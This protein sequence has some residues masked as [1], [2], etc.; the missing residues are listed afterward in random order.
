MPEILNIEYH[1]KILMHKALNK[2]S[3]LKEAAK[4]LRITEQTIYKYINDWFIWNDDKK[5]WDFIC[6]HCRASIKIK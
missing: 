2:Y 6:A 3:T 1:T 5:R 4:R